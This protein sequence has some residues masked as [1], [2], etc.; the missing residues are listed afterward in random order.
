MQEAFS[1]GYSSD[2]FNNAGAAYEY[3]VINITDETYRIHY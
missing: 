1:E 2:I 3:S